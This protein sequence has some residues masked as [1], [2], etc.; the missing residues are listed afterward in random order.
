MVPGTAKKVWPQRGRQHAKAAVST[1]MDQGFGNDISL[2][3][4]TDLR[5]DEMLLV[6]TAT[7]TSAPLPFLTSWELSRTAMEHAQ[8]FRVTYYVVMGLLQVCL[9]KL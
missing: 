1:I 6:E 4:E 3:A 7:I 5:I 8:Y 2:S 9:V